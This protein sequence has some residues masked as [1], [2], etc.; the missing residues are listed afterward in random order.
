MMVLTSCKTAREANS[1][2]E[3]ATV[4]GADAD[5]FS[6]YDIQEVDASDRIATTAKI[7]KSA[8]KLCITKKPLELKISD[9]GGTELLSWKFEG[10]EPLRC[11]R[12]Y[13]FT[14][15]T[16]YSATMEGLL[17]DPKKF[18]F[19]LVSRGLGSAVKISATRSNEN[20]GSSGRSTAAS[21]YECGGFGGVEEYRVDI[22]LKTNQA[23]F[24]DNDTTSNMTLKQVR[25]LE[26]YP[27]QT[28]M[29][30]E[31]PDASSSGGK[32]NL[33][34]NLTNLEAY[35]LSIS[36]SGKTTSIGSASCKA[37]KP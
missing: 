4:K 27:P 25:Q 7:K 17:S 13:S 19:S 1:V 21:Y 35:L 14:G 36:K 8:K 28:E 10:Y 11:P 34:F 33:L 23:S 12:C 15:G 3:D 2:L 6:C 5:I 22:D 32:I 24:F 16:A 9:A 20:S 30:F 29:E 37:G 26:S 31:G 18:T